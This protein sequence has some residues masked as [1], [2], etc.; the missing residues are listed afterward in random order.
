MQYSYSSHKV[1]G[2][3]FVYGEMTTGNK[4]KKW[5]TAV[6]HSMER[7]NIFHC[8]STHEIMCMPTGVVAFEHI[9]LADFVEKMIVVTI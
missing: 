5:F 9:F 7:K 8:L 3:P 4:Q 2:W 1:K 6:F